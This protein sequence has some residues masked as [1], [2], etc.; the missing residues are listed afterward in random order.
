MK[1]EGFW[2]KVYSGTMQHFI[3]ELCRN[4]DWSYA[5]HIPQAAMASLMDT[6]LTWYIPG[7]GALLSMA[8]S[9]RQCSFSPSLSHASPFW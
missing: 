3:H 4:K 7:I 6:Q 2:G 5:W 8:Q 1:N 9:G